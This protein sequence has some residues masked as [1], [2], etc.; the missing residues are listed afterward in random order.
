VV[1]ARFPEAWLA[2]RRLLRLS[3]EGFRLFVV[4]LLWSV[5]NRT[6]GRVDREDLVLMPGTDSGRTPELE[7]AGLWVPREDGSWLIADFARTQTSRDELEV[8]E[9]ARRREREKKARQR[10]EKAGTV[11]REVPPG[12]SPGTAQEGRKARQGR[13]AATGELPA[14]DADEGLSAL[15]KA[16]RAARLGGW[17][18]D[19]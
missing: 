14:P 4:A 17:R 5:A 18:T 13:Q 15:A 3:A 9:N 10:A 2:D 6:D 7:K 1:D 16:Q 11:P 19:E 12:Q 8:L